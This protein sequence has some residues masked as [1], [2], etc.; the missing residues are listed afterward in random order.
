MTVVT[1][2]NR[3]LYRYLLLRNALQER[4]KGQTN[5]TY[6]ALGVGLVTLSVLIYGALR[7]GIPSKVARLLG[8]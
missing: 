3:L 1:W 2:Q 7:A 5:M 8:F 4:H 6:L